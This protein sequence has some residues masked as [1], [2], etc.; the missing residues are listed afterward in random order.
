MNFRYILSAAHCA[1][2]VDA[3]KDPCAY[4]DRGRAVATFDPV[5]SGM[6]AFLGVTNRSEMFGPQGKKNAFEIDK[7]LHITMTFLSVDYLLIGY[8]RL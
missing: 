7:V 8:T 6:R 4:D 1:C 2:L 3:P 5:D